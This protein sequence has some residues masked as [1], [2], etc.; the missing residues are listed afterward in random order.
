MKFSRFSLPLFFIF[1]LSGWC[2]SQKNAHVP[3]Q[4][5]VSLQP[6]VEPET[7]VRRMAEDIAVGSE[8]EKK[9]S[10]LLN[11]W[12]LSSPPSNEAAMLEWLQRQ[13]DVR[14]AQYNHVLENRG[15]VLPDD[16]LISQQWQYVNTGAN[17]GVPNADLD[18]D[19]AWDIATGGVTP[20]GDTI[21]MAVIDGGIDKNH[22]DLA[23]NLWKNYA[24]IPNDGIDN[25]NN[26]YVDD[27]RGWNVFTDNDNI[28]GVATGHGTPVSAIIGAKGN[29]GNGVAGINWNV[30]IMFVAGGSNEANILESYDYVLKA[31]KRYNASN[32]A[33]GAFVVAVNCSW[34][35]NYGQPSEAPLWCAAFD[36]LGAAGI[37][38]VAA[39]A[40]IPVDVDVVGDLPT[41]CPSDYL[42]SVTSLTRADQK[43]AN[44]AWGVIHIDLGAYGQEV[45]TAGTNNSYG[46]YS[47]TSFAAPQVAGALGLLYSAPCPNLIAIAKTNPAAAALWAKSLVLN[48]TTP[49][50]ALQG[51]T[52][53]SGRLNL[54]SMLQ[55]YE[56][57]CDPCPPPFALATADITDHSTLIKWSEISDYQSVVL[58][59]RK[60]G[61]D[62]WNTV[63]DVA[64]SYLLAGLSACTP[65][66]F[67]LSAVCKQGASSDWSA[68][69]TFK[70]DGCCEP[71]A[72]L[73]VEWTNT[74][75]A[76]VAWSPVTAAKGYRLQVRPA[77]GNWEEYSTDN[78]AFSLQDLLPCT[79][80]EARVQTIC[81]TGSTPFSGVLSFTTSGCGSCT[82]AGYCPAKAE[83]SDGEWISSVAVGNWVY[84]SG[85]GGT[86]YQD[87]TGNQPNVLQLTPQSIENVTIIPGFGG[88]PYKEYFRIYVDFNMDGDFN[89]PGE[90]AYGPAW[91]TDGPSSGTLA[92]PGFSASGL[93]RMR[94]MMKYKGGNNLPPSP[95]ESFDFGQVEDY[96]VNLAGFVPATEE[97]LGEATLNISPQP[98]GD[99]V[100]LKLPGEAAGSCRITVWDM[101]GRRIL[102]TE[103]E[104]E[105]GA[106]FRLNTSTW[107]AGAFSVQI[108]C[109][110]SI[111]TGL[112]MK[113]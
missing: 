19:L 30:Q 32:G 38:S 4:V 54:Y 103:E 65:Y 108:I 73:W 74:S 72:S 33:A 16:P 61:S 34:G 79:H 99:F 52:L 9:V 62:T 5:L 48:S 59:W 41:A 28:G 10:G 60:T 109:S 77:N 25:D 71:P 68:P 104:P 57:Q 67:S 46:V 11:I 58:R 12:L 111:Y 96:C 51:I 35:T 15:S 2:F 36:S 64:G 14:M 56:D 92:T 89:D 93:T 24:E 63:N 44:A 18:A 78:T 27:F 82:D 80:Y 95:C 91:A 105:Q 53:T 81:D 55:E 23:A 85:S 76:S 1:F 86:G 102:S 100:E 69:V 75:A 31:R 84:E 20:A 66:E 110:N 37:L 39:T 7:L 29:N 90:L 83:H 87:F 107:P 40:N 88:L 42:I 101:T 22:S 94:V 47:G 21:V 106:I 97:Y 113:K 8:A 43:A 6:G 17:G 98:A 70:T 3:G 45:F 49:N 112:V 50:N 26:G 13:P